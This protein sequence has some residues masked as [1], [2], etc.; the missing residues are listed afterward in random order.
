M[1]MQVLA[2]GVLA[3]IH[4]TAGG[5]G[6]GNLAGPGTKAE[7]G[8]AGPA[9]TEAL[10]RV[11]LVPERETTLVAPMVGTVQQLSADLGG[12]VA[13]GAIVARFECSEQRARVGMARAELQSASEQLAAKERLQGL[14]AAGDVEVSLAR[15]ALA[16]ARA[17]VELGQAQAAHCAVAAPFSGRI[18]RLHIREHQGVNVGQPIID[19]VSTGPL[20][21]RLNAPSRWLAWLKPGAAFS[22]Q[23]DE[24]GRTYRAVLTAINA[25]VDAASQSIELEGRIDG[26]PPELLAGMSGVARFGTPGP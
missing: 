19:L 21:V 2:I 1:A 12:P 26:N 6:P 17:Q 7:T 8:R 23:I 16:K 4:G 11:L 14:A 20:R 24:T 13:R 25:R 9:A 15:A 18:A 5:Q 22:V 10:P 3:G